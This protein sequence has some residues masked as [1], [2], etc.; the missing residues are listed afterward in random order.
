MWLPFFINYRS[1]SVGHLCFGFIQCIA[2]LCAVLLSCRLLWMNS[3]RKADNDDDG[4]N[5]NSGSI[6]GS[7]MLTIRA[8][9]FV[10]S[11]HPFLFVCMCLGL[12][13]IARIYTYTYVLPN[14]FM[15]DSYATVPNKR[16]F[17]NVFRFAN[18]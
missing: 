6:N 12:C 17:V 8:C 15:Y 3:V 4:D 13:H 11:I 7:S 2:G 9:T 16:D 10:R 5:G 18:A 1:F 14:F